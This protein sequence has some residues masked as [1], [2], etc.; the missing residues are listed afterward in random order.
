VPPPCPWVRF[1]DPADLWARADRADVVVTHGGNTARLVQRR[2]RIPIVAARAACHG[3][4]GN[5]HQVEWLDQER[6]KGRVVV[7]DFA[8]LAEQVDVHTETE[9]RL[10]RERSVTRPTDPETLVRRL[11]RL[12][13]LNRNVANPF[14][15]H[16][17]RRYAFAFAQ[18]AGRRGRHLD[19]G[20]ERGEFLAALAEHSDL[21]AEGAEPLAAY[22]EE[23]QARYPQLKVTRIDPRRPLPF[24]DAEFDSAS[25]LDVLEHTRDERETLREVHRILRP[26][27]LLVVSVPA[28]HTFSWCDPDNAKLRFPRLHRA[29]YT[30]RF[31]RAV[32]HARFVDL[33]D[34]MRGDMA[35]ERREHTNYRPSEL[36]GLLQAAGFDPVLRDGA[37][38][39]WRFFQIPQLF[40]PRGWRWLLDAPLRLDGRWFRAANLFIVAERRG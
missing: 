26:G 24:G 37:N 15:D 28:R 5:D 13:L 20:C 38:L 1:L 29:V 11:D 18:L 19:L 8:R 17:T 7:A 30:A 16:P 12:A 39:F 22:R 6:I 33:S 21:A 10:L 4:M 3:E 27:A 36:L 9:T 14:A 32:Y 23:L 2:N 25:L 35:E 40:L 34:G 31:G